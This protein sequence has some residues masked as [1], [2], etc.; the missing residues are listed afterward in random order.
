[1]GISDGRDGAAANAASVRV[2]EIFVRF[3]RG[4]RKKIGVRLESDMR[5][6][7]AAA[8]GVRSPEV[9]GQREGEDALSMTCA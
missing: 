1:M 4:V 5:F 8:R 3:G 7:E 9:K 2:P 6:M